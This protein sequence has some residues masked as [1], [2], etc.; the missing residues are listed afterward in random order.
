[1][2]I[3][4][5]LSEADADRGSVGPGRLLSP[6]AVDNGH[7]LEEVFQ[8]YDVLFDRQA[9]LQFCRAFHCRSDFGNSI[10]TEAASVAFHAMAQSLNGP[11]VLLQ[12]RISNC[13]DI[14]PPVI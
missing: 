2:P 6:L 9:V 10:E 8:L 13:P 12:Q 1:M 11:E 4:D 5:L 14:P 3:W 7:A